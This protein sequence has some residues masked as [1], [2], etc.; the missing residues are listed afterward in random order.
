MNKS[1]LT[2]AALAAFTAC[3]APKGTQQVSKSP[4]N[5][6]DKEI[7]SK[8]M[9]TITPEDLKEHL[10]TF[11]SDEFEGRETGERGQKVAADYLTKFYFEQGL[12]GPVAGVP[13]PYLQKFTLN[14]VQVN[15]YTVETKH[16]KGENFEDF[17]AYGNFNA[18]AIDTEYVFLGTGTEADFSTLSM[19]G[20][21]AVIL[22]ASEG[23][24]S[25][26]RA[27]ITLAKSKGAKAIMI[28]MGSDQEFASRAKFFR[29]YSAKP[30]LS[31]DDAK[32][33]DFGILFSSPKGVKKLFGLGED[34]SLAEV[35]S[36][37]EFKA[38]NYVV[39]GKLGAKLNVGKVHTENVMAFMEGTDLKDEVV[40]ISSHYDHVGINDGEVYN[41]ADDDGSGT[42]GVLEIAEAFVTAAKEGYRPRRSVLFLNFTGEE[43]GLL[44]SEYYSDNPIIPLEKTIVDLN[45][46]MIGR[47]DEAH[48]DNPNFIYIIGSDMLSSGLHQLH[49][50]VAKEAVPNIELDYK[51]NDKNDPN[52][53]YYRSDHYNFAK[54]NI[55]V[56]FYFNGTHE[57]YHQATDTPDKI[58]Y[59]Q[60]ALRAKL[61]FATAWE[62]ANRNEKP[63]VDKAPAESEAKQN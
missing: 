51:Y 37:Q 1:I 61:I 48:K 19:E 33:S 58:A 60:Q 15:D 28:V 22:D 43:K 32:S 12:A 49:E 63:V 56:I 59:E 41:G 62:I 5:I 2:A 21:V 14:S 13:N 4:S 17:V 55:P 23:K 36:S 11:A 25:D 8:Y 9:N 46:D 54:H 27:K 10:M 52:R 42:T 34:V 20:K 50:E 26:T 31:F 6:L 40:V 53:F 57:D 45:V 16:H 44:G 30:S 38:A 18:E 35:A 7:V 29:Q 39:E 24:R 47:I 3:Q